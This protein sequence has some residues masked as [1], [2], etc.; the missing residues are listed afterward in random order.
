M[1]SKL[2]A[3]V[4]GVF[5]M[6]SSAASDFAET[7]SVETDRLEELA[8]FNELNIDR[9]K[10][11]DGFTVQDYIDS[12]KGYKEVSHTAFSDKYTLS[13]P[14]VNQYPDLPTGCEL[15]AAV[16]VIEYN[17]NKIGLTDFT[18]RFV[19]CD[20]NFYHDDEGIL[21]GPD[22]A[23][24]FVGD[25]YGWGYGCYPAVLAEYMDKA[26]KSLGVEYSSHAVT[27]LS[28]EELLELV[29]GGVPVIVWAS[30]DMKAFD[31]REPSVWR[32]YET[33]RELTWYKGS[34]TLVL[35]G[36]DKDAFYFMDP[37]DKTEIVAYGRGLFMRRY[38]EAGA[39]AVIVKR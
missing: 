7:T 24:V 26:F 27:G 8:V 16:S 36:A 21:H 10:L 11:Y 9:G 12:Y 18:D 17:G 23:E 25:P 31:Y 1:E 38:S 20:E 33:E 15:A 13:V 32:I 6:L 37:N 3:V 39:R 28:E 4:L 35:C 2:I 19:V 14:L 29:K 22:P 34:H 30:L 5:A